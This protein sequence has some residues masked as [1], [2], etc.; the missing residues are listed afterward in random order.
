M[1]Q[2]NA[3]EQ[4]YNGWSNRETWAVKLWIDNEESSYH[5]WQE[6]TY[7]A[8][9]EAKNDSYD[10]CTIN[11]MRNRAIRILSNR[12]EANHEEGT[13]VLS[14]NIY[15]DLLT[16]SLSRVDWREIAESLITDAEDDDENLW[17][18]E[19]EDEE[20]KTE[21]T[22]CD[23]CQAAMIQ[24]IYCH[25][26]GCPN[27]HKVKVDGEWVTPQAE[28]EVITEFWFETYT[29]E[30][31]SEQ[32]HGPFTTREEAEE[33]AREY[34]SEARESND[35]TPY[36]GSICTKEKGYTLSN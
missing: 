24:G 7:Q 17:E 14:N 18:D 31:F 8:I 6:E 12:L 22:S 35:G 13:P 10:V 3:N 16:Y 29:N 34:Q 1:P 33:A 5:F 11:N 26:T 9:E 4:G 21:D 23:S 32:Q 36:V 15:S 19:D 2:A 27:T 28:T 20:E 30:P 25:E